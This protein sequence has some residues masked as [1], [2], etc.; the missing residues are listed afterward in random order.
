MTARVTFMQWH[1]YEGDSNAPS[2]CVL[3]V[4]ACMQ[5]ADGARTFC[6]RS[7]GDA[8]LLFFSRLCDVPV[9]SAEKAAPGVL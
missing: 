1:V 3:L 5:L 9:R 2:V 7:V 6:G 8:G 4:L